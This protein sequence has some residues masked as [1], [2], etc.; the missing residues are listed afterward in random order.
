MKIFDWLYEKYLDWRLRQVYPNGV[1]E[2]EYQ[3][4]KRLLTRNKKKLNEK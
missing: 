4:V 3:E 1:S 2:E